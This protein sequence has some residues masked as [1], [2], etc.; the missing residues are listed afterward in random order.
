MLPAAMC[1]STS[2]PATIRWWSPATAKSRKLLRHCH[3][4]LQPSTVVFQT[5]GRQQVEAAYAR[6]QD[7]AG[8]DWIIVVAVPR[9][10]FLAR[11]RGKLQAHAGACAC[12]RR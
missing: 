6:M 2:K 1:E 11:G 8:L 10:D 3:R 5:G 7:A 9:S 4:P 12:S